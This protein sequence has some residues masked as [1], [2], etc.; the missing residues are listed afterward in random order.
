M[1]V[2]INLTDR[3]AVSGGFTI[4]SPPEQASPGLPLGRWARIGKRMEGR[5]VSAAE[6]NT[7][8]A[9][10]IVSSPRRKWGGRG[11]SQPPAQAMAPVTGPE[12]LSA[13][14]P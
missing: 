7:E 10:S 14:A 8:T 11:R 2:V 9:E 6:A 12:H 5:Q 1:G 3:K 13:G 4:L